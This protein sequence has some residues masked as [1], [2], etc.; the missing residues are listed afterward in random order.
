MHCTVVTGHT[1]QRRVLVE[2]DAVGMTESEW[3]VGGGE[4]GGENGEQSLNGVHSTVGIHK[5]CSTLREVGYLAEG[6]LG[7]KLSTTVRSL[8]HTQT[9]TAWESV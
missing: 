3:G 9:T 1:Q 6:S 8:A 7:P 4:G 2:V 5:V